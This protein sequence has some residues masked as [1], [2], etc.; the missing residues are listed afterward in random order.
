MIVVDRYRP[1]DRPALDGLYRRVLGDERAEA[2][3]QRW[4]WTY[5]RNPNLPDGTPLIWLARD[6]GTIVGQYAT[7]PV[8]LWVDGSEIGAAWGTDVMVAP[9]GQRQGLGQRLFTAWDE[10]V[11][12][13][14]GLGLTDASHGLF[15]KLRWPDLGRVPRLVKR[16]V[17][18]GSEGKLAALRRRWRE[19]SARIRPIGGEVRRVTR[20]DEGATEL[21]DSVAARFAFAVRRD[22]TYL[23]W[24]FVQR[25]EPRYSIATLQRGSRTAGWVVY[26]HVDEPQGRVTLLVD[27]LC[28]PADGGALRALLRWVD[29]EALA[30]GS[31]LVRVFATFGAY[32]R[33]L[34]DAGY[35]DG[36]A[37]MRLVAKINAVPVAP[38]FY[39]STERWHVTL[40]DSDA[41]R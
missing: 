28:D 3:H 18:E 13:S 33:T 25:P 30:Q 2:L 39:A 16:F 38:S 17:A 12:A 21:W 14:I 10:G 6:G 31:T 22:A 9:E 41:D 8:R 35:R 26:R 7:M 19:A 36:S 29:R 4:D 11:G 5:L 37:G 40:G 34:R 15:Q 20:F 23:N 24:K 1:A 32:H 27:F